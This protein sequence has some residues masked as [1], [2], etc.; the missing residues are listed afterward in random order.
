MA[1]V[2]SLIDAESI[3]KHERTGARAPEIKP[4]SGLILLFAIGMTVGSGTETDAFMW[5]RAA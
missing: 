3:N 2:S 5:L 1:K 4:E